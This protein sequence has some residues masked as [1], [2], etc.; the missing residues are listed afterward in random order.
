[1]IRAPAEPLEGIHDLV[2]D[3]A[4]LVKSLVD[5]LEQHEVGTS[6]TKD[7]EVVVAFGKRVATK[8]AQFKETLS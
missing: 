7:A 5:Y 1:V 3:T 4:A 6:D 2:K 8:A